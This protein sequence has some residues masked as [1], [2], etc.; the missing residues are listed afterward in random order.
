M[1]PPYRSP[2]KLAFALMAL[3]LIA[4]LVVYFACGVNAVPLCIIAV[5]P[6]WIVH[7]IR[8]HDYIWKYYPELARQRSKAW[9]ANRGGLSRYEDVRSE[10]ENLRKIAR[11]H[12]AI[13]L[14]VILYF[15]GTAILGAI[16]E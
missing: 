5:M 13:P 14:I 15:V 2:M 11:L 16:L 8:A 4:A 6:I 9:F 10:D 3:A 7:G 12:I 1:R